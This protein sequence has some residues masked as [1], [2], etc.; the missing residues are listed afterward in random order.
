MD[1]LASGRG[2][3]FG[4]RRATGKQRFLSS[5]GFCICLVA[6]GLVTAQETPRPPDRPLSQG[7]F[8]AELNG[9]KLWFKVSG[10]GPVCLMPTAPRSPSS[11]IYFR[12]LQPLEKMFT[13]VY[14]DCRGTGRS[15]PHRRKS[16]PGSVWSLIWTRCEP[17][18]C[19]S[20]DRGLPTVTN[21]CWDTDHSWCSPT[22]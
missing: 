18:S 5:I 16:T 20:R 10:T 9:L 17:M 2:S 1:S 12:T 4:E 11:D 6:L 7:E 19:S 21:R 14:L 15:Q 13:L 3:V 22:I 8:T